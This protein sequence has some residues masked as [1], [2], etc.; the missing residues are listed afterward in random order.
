MDQLFSD[1]QIKN[2]EAD[3]PWKKSETDK[4]LDLYFAGAHPKRIAT[5]LQRNPKA[6]KRRLEQFTYNERDRANRYEPVKRMSR[7]GQRITENEKAMIVAYKARHLPMAM[8]AKVLQRAPRE[9]GLDSTDLT[10]LVDFKKVGIGVDLVLAY[11]YLYYVKGISILSDQAYDKLEAEE[12]EFGSN[13]DILNKAVGSDKEDDYP[14]H[15]RALALYLAFRYASP[16]VNHPKE[17]II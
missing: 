14:N 6:V 15:V 11:R 10:R 9:L 16:A 5:I 4:M 1:D 7:K 13:G 2:K 17:K 12:I 8:L 3:E